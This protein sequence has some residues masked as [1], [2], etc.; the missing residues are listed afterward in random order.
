MR[1]LRYSILSLMSL[2]LLAACFVFLFIF[3]ATL[4][5]PLL[6]GIFRLVLRLFAQTPLAGVVQV[7]E[8]FQQNTP[9]FVPLGLSLLVLGTLAFL[10]FKVYQWS[11]SDLGDVP[12]EMEA[13]LLQRRG[14]YAKALTIYKRIGRWDRAAEI[15]QI[16]RQYPEAAQMLERLGEESHA[17]AAELYERMGDLERARR[18]YRSA[19]HYYRQRQEWEKAAA[20]YLKGDDRQGAL[21][22][23]EAQFKEI[24]TVLP[25]EQM[26]E[27]AQRIVQLAQALALPLV[28]AQHCEYAKDIPGAVTAYIQGGSYLKAAQLQIDHKDPE[29]AIVT[30]SK[31]AAEHRQYLESL[32]ILGRLLFQR[33]MFAEALKRYLE[34]FKKAKVS[35]ATIDEFYQL[36]LCLEKFGQL[37]QAKD[38]FARIHSMRP[39]Y[40]NVDERVD[41]IEHKKDEH[42]ALDTILE[43]DTAQKDQMLSDTFLGRLGERYT[44]LQELGRG[45]AG[46]VYK[47]RDMIL[48]RPVALKQLPP[49]GTDDQSWLQ[50]F[51]REAKS[52]A[53]LNHPN[54]VTIYD[55]M[56]LGNNY[57]IVMEFINGT[58]VDKL[59]E[60]NGPMSLKLSLY[61]ARCVLQ[62]LG[63]A[64]RSGVI[65][66]DIKPANIMLTDDRTV[67][68][69]DFGIAH[70]LDELPDHSTE[71]VMGTPKY[72]SPEQIQGYP[73][74]E[75]SDLYSFGITLYEMLTGTLPFPMEGIFHH[76]LHTLPVPPRQL[77]P[78]IPESLEKVVLRCL[79]KSR[80]NRYQTAAAVLRDLKVL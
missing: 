53:K 48:D 76:H 6:Q 61:V 28:A 4:Q 74:N 79:Q 18:S 5:L 59:I 46:I 32:L 49:E 7:L 41:A 24:R 75:S 3:S 16:Q 70:L 66:Q 19:G 9:G 8:A 10:D 14:Q 69:T 31:L 62:A 56:K 78:G 36:G 80:E 57:F 25:L 77:H 1:A 60:T 15:Y 27:K 29:G 37:K 58:G 30:L 73:V 47:A 21:D 13:D 23:Y 54:I 45:G 72:I 33:Q 17:T 20:F 51:F 63:Y 22:C 39:F 55:I 44:E 26:K 71:T 40:M 43:K 2:L 65:H 38:V 68:L 42:V 11:R 12:P 50:S 34:Y 35:D 52:I 67:K 64:H